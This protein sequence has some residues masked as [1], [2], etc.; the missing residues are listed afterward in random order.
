[1]CN[2][3]ALSR[4]RKK[5]KNKKQAAQKWLTTV[6]SQPE[7]DEAAVKQPSS[8]SHTAIPGWYQVLGQAGWDQEPQ[9]K[10]DPHR[11]TTV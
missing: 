6:R 5:K 10:A 11:H 2:Q 1:M 7:E 3:A 8:T 4:H 9:Q